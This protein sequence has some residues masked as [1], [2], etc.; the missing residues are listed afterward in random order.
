VDKNVFTG[1]F[2]RFRITRRYGSTVLT[3][4]G[5]C[6]KNSRCHYFAGCNDPKTIAGKLKE[7]IE[8][9]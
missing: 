9:L 1:D 6:L 5:P 8:R 4:F 3:V 7:M 2:R